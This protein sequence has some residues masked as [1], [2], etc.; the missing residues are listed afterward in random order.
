MDKC[1]TTSF[2]CYATWTWDPANKVCYF[3]AASGKAIMDYTDD[4][5]GGISINND[6]G[7]YTGKCTFG[8]ATYY[9]GIYYASDMITATLSGGT[10]LGHWAI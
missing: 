5:G 8:T 4:V 2:Q 10:I 1:N 7:T 6:P 3:N 9:Y